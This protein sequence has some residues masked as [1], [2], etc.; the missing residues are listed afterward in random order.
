MT[1]EFVYP[2][3]KHPRKVFSRIGLALFIY[4]I[5]VYIS[6]YIFSFLSSEF[7]PALY[8]S[9]YFVWINMI[10]C[11]YVIGAS[12]IRL[13]LL[14][15][16]TYKYPKEKMSFK[17]LFSAFIICQGLSY[18]GNII[19]MLL[20]QIISSMLGK[21]IDNTVNSIISES[22]II[23]VFLVVGIIGPIMEEL[24]F[25][26]FIIDRT[27]PYGEALAVLFSG[28]TFGMFHGNFYQLFYSCA[29]GIVLAFIYVRTKNILYPIILH[30]AFNTLSVMSEA[31][32]R[33][34]SDTNL[35][36]LINGIFEVAGYML[37]IGMLVMTILG[38]IKFIK[39]IKKVYFIKNIYQI[40]KGKAFLY[41]A[42]NVGMIL[43]FISVLAEFAMSIFL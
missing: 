29:I 28:L 34:S 8:S 1:E 39:S 35:T 38:I 14:G 32:S 26:K 22:N 31:L 23:I 9:S 27:R 41:T 36:Q 13:V 37:T 17:D 40:P 43:F 12:L 6:S 25:R 16:P 24:I 18:A 42:I 5:A 4:F 15:L 10:L 20:N 33:G 3:L 7:F 19:G 30:C 21:E 11:Q 2:R